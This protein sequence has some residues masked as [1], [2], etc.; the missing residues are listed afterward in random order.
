[1]VAVEL[2]VVSLEQEGRLT[3][4]VFV[5]NVCK[6]PVAVLCWWQWEYSTGG[7][8]VTLVV[9]AVLS[10]VVSLEPGADLQSRSYT[11]LLEMQGQ[12]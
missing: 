7:G 8:C 10:V 12:T 11:C 9:M 3:R 5:C 1:M 4:N 6:S 2:S